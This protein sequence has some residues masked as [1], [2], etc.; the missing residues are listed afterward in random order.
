[1]K[2][3][4]EQARAIAN[5]FRDTADAVA[6]YTNKYFHE[7]SSNEVFRLDSFEWDLRTYTSN[8]R[9]TIVGMV[10]DGMEENLQAI[11]DATAGA[12]KAIK[13]IER[14]KSVIKL[15]TALVML[16]GAITSQNLP[17]IGQATKDVLDAVAEE[18]K[19]EG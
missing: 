7:L 13:Q 3:T 16:G 11:A 5:S 19:K 14:V 6:D 10:L 9:T 17:A 8:F 15:A 2:L 18:R 4:V 12:K 1:M